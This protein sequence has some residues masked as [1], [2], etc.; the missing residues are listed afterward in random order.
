MWFHT[1]IAHYSKYT[2]CTLSL[3]LSFSLEYIF[4]EL[5]LFDDY[6]QSWK[7]EN[8]L[9]DERPI[10]VKELNNDAVL[11]PT[12]T[13]HWRSIIFRQFSALFVTVVVHNVY[14]VNHK[15]CAILDSRMYF[16]SCK[17]NRLIVRFGWI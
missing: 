10:F 2:S 5:L 11:P 14:R 13:L 8:V 4:L 1:I 16:F 9:W 3:S 15:S 7:A 12:Y 17:I 6:A